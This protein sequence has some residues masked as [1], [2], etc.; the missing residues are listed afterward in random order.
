MK[1]AWF[2]SHFLHPNSGGS[3]F[4]IDYASGL[5]NIHK[6]DIQVYCDMA[7][8]EARKLF[9][10]ENIPLIELDTNST[11]SA[12][13]W[14]TLTSRLKRKK[15]YLR[16]NISS[17]TMLISSM[18]PMNLLVNSLPNPSIQMCYEPF[19][20]F[21]DSN[22]LRNFKSIYRLFFKVMRLIY[23][24][25]DYQATNQA[26]VLLTIN[27]TNI[28]KIKTVYG[29][30]PGVVYAGID[31]DLYKRSDISVV[32]N[33]RKKHHGNPLLFH[34]TDLTGTKGSYF[35]LDVIKLL[36]DEFPKIK[37]LFTIYV[38]DP[39]GTQFFMEKIKELGIDKNCEFLGCL[40]K[41]K[42]PDYYSSVDFV[43]QPSLNQPANWPLKEALLCETPII[44]GIESEEVVDF[45]NGVKVNIKNS[46]ESANKIIELIKKRDQLDTL[47][48]WK[49]LMSKQYS[50]Y[51][52]IEKLNSI[53]LENAGE[54]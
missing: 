34:S 11:N 40:A 12:F 22:F 5:K 17:D 15:K 19:A 2:H 21:Y 8:E 24:T 7:N 41:D 26:K 37:L 39:I 53:L 28:P 46:A 32:K 23:S 9:K 10:A 50:K 42:L 51:L 25:K 47:A 31:V 6:Q 38:N 27:E 49:E 54:S 45:V 33:L 20:F 13:Y 18:F 48:Y 4:V 1:I 36:K 43:C 35:L 29:R 44:G 3:R 14:L 30:T 16:E 52:F